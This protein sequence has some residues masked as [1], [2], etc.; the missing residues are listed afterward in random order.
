MKTNTTTSMTANL[1]A[2]RAQAKAHSQQLASAAAVQ[3]A[4]AAPAPTWP[5]NQPIGPVKVPRSV[6]ARPPAPAK[7]IKLEQCNV[8]LTPPARKRIRAAA[9][10][11]HVSEQELIERWAMT[12]PKPAPTPAMPWEA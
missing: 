1:D 6:R 2:V 9:L 11:C 10:A 5:A 12:L 4:P 7:A 3:P 8:R